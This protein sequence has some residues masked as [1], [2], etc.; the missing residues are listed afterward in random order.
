MKGWGVW[1]SR[2]AAADY[3]ALFR[4]SNKHKEVYQYAL[5]YQTFHRYNKLVP[6][7]NGSRRIWDQMG[8]H[9][10]CHDWKSVNLNLQLS[11]VLK[12]PT[13]TLQSS[14][15]ALTACCLNSY[16]RFTTFSKRVVKALLVGEV[17]PLVSWIAAAAPRCKCL[18]ALLIHPQNSS[19]ICPLHPTWAVWTDCQQLPSL[20]APSAVTLLIHF[21][22]SV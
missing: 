18:P 22:V 17:W 7:Y 20:T 4:T 2:G 8:G 5:I 14:T 1:I 3:V 11:P 21:S 10:C 9:K 16:V 6:L 13:Q 15:I 19:R 12:S